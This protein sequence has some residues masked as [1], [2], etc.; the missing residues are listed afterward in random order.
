MPKFR[1]SIRELFLATLVEAACLG[2]YVHFRAMEKAA[3]DRVKAVENKTQAVAEY[4]ERLKKVLTNSM[5]CC[6]DL[7]N[8]AEHYRRLAAGPD[9]KLN[10]FKPN[11]KVNWGILREPPP[12]P[13]SAF[14]SGQIEPLPDFGVMAPFGIRLYL[15]SYVDNARHAPQKGRS[16]FSFLIARYCRNAKRRLSPLPNASCR[17][18]RTCGPNGCLPKVRKTLHDASSRIHCRPPGG[19]DTTTAFVSAPA[20]NDLRANLA[21]ATAAIAGWWVVFQVV[22][23]RVGCAAGDVSDY[24]W[25]RFPSRFARVRRML[26]YYQFRGQRD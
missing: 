11:V 8:S 1:F 26:R 10:P 14:L 24:L 12:E 3:N 2:W 20:T 6:D 25:R 15:I 17:L 4:A 9:A 7:Q 18:P 21:T 16:S 22:C 19:T 5:E 13:V 23:V